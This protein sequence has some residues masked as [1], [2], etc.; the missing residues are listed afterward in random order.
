MNLL[1]L[2]DEHG[3]KYRR[4]Q[5]DETEIFICCLFCE[6]KGQNADT[7]FRCGLNV[8]N[9]KG[10]CFN[11]E[12]KTRAAFSEVAAILGVTVTQRDVPVQ[13]ETPSED[14]DQ[15][16]PLSLPDD[17][18]TFQKA[19]SGILFDRALR[20]VKERGVKDWQIEE[21]KIGVSFTGK[22]AY[23]IIFPIYF[24]HELQGFVG[25]DFTKQQKLPYLNMPGNKSLYN[26]PRGRRAKKVVLCEGIFDCLAIEQTVRLADYDVMAVLGRS[27]TE[28]QEE[29][30]ADYRD[31]ILW[32]D[33]DI[34][35]VKGFIDVAKHLNQKHRVFVVPPSSYGKDAAEMKRVHR[36]FIWT[37]RCRF[38]SNVELRLRAE[39]AFNAD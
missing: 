37:T 21:K 28:L 19:P 17:F 38:D 3:I 34:P 10:H 13:G 27:L 33:G 11:C 25:R 15:S 12:W 8:E 23:R 29:Q 30:I 2:L 4:S 20:Y 7:R 35:G 22:Y 24:K 32:P 16:T 18:V 39:V 31:V 5:F 14:S 26:V 36:D 1:E 6:S 9:D